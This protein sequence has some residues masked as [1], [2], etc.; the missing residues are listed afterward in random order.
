MENIHSHFQCDLKKGFNAQ[1]CLIGMIEKAKIIMHKD[2]DFSALLTDQSKAFK[3]LSH[4]LLIAK[5]DAYGFKNGAL[6]S[7]FNFFNNRRQ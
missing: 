1:L 5:L 3:C 4:D 6:Y 7:I 2:E